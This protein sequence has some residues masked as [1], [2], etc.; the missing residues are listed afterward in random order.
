MFVSM[1][2]FS[3]SICP[4]HQI[5]KRASGN[6]LPPLFSTGGGTLVPTPRFLIVRAVDNFV[7]I[8][9]L[10][11]NIQNAEL[12]RGA[13]KRQFVTGA[14]RELLAP[15]SRIPLIEYSHVISCTNTR[16]SVF[17]FCC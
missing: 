5:T 13:I 14:R 15:C 9:K 17:L 8:L 3:T 2:G 16:T 4:Y 10:K 6:L 1:N 7:D 11:Y 12:I